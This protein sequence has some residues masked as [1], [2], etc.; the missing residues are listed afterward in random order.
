MPQGIRTAAMNVESR[1]ECGMPKGMR[2]TAFERL[3]V[4]G[5][6]L[7][8]SG[9]PLNAGGPWSSSMVHRFVGGFP[10]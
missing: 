2:N 1:K 8:V 3:I 7:C 10:P 6:P 9:I 4:C 5:L